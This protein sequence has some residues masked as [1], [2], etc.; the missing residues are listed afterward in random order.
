MLL[1]FIFLIPLI[2]LGTH[3]WHLLNVKG[4][5]PRPVTTIATL[6]TA[7]IIIAAYTVNIC[8]LIP[9]AP[10]WPDVF[11]LWIVLYL[12]AKILPCRQGAEGLEAL[13]IKFNCPYCQEPLCFHRKF[14]NLHYP[15]S[16]CGEGVTV[17]SDHAVHERDME[18]RREVEKD[19]ELSQQ[20][21]SEMDTNNDSPSS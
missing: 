19:F 18:E 7:G 14:E 5:N 4:Y 21:N 9:V 12:A 3:V 6:A 2:A 15:C 17:T 10:P 20:R 13:H 16:N 11:L 8:V 1:W